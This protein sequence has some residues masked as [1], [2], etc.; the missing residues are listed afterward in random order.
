[1]VTTAP[2]GSVTAGS[3]FGLVVS[4]EDPFGNVAKSFAT[5][6]TLALATNPNGATLGG[7]STVNASSGVATFSGLTLN[8]AGAGAT[9]RASGT[10]LSSA[11]TGAIT[12]TAATA[13]QLVV[14]T[15]PPGSVTA[16][17]GF[18]FVVAA[19][20]PFGNVTPSFTS[21]LTL[22]LA[23]NPN[24][25]NLGGTLAV[26]ASAGVATF[27]GLTLNKTGTGASLLVSNPGLTG[28][29]TSVITV[30]P[31]AA[32]QLL[33][34]TSP[35]ASVTA[36]SGFGL[37]VTAEDLFGNVAT[38]FASSVTLGLAVNPNGATLGGTL[39]VNAGA[40]VATFSSLTLNKAGA[41]TTLG[42]SSAG[43]SA[44]TTGALTVTSAKA[45][46][47][48]LTTQPP[49]GVT[50]GNAFGLVA[51]AEDPFGNVDPSFVSSVN[52]ALA[53]N[54]NGAILGGTPTV[55]A[56]AGVATFSGLTLDEAGAVVTLGAS[57]SGLS[58]ATTGAITVAAETATRLVVTAQPSASVSAGTGFG[59]VVMAEDGFGNVDSTFTGGVSLTLANNP[60]G[61]TLGGASTVHA[62]AGVATFS[63][64]TLNKAGSGATLG[65]S[66]A[67]VSSTTTGAV[68]VTAAT[69]SQL[70]V[71]T[72]PPGNVTAGS[73][74][75]LVVMAE[76]PFGNVNPNFASN[77]TLALANNP[78][79]A[80]LGGI[81]AVNAAA[82][83]ATFSGLILNK[84]GTG[85]SLLVSC[86]G[87]TA[88]TTSD[89]TVTPGTA[90]QLLVTA[91]PPASV[92][93]GSGFG[94]G[95]VAE[96]PFGNTATNFAAS[97]TL[98]LAN[99]PNG[100][101]LGGTLAI[102]AAAGVATFSG[103]TLNKAGTGTT[104]LGFPV[105]A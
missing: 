97:V 92:T 96:D 63:G 30:T 81:L 13:S 17:S 27:S 49:A 32:T 89:I 5:S 98:T 7:T 37:V 75:G 57:A 48:V 25:A 100:A 14:T 70:V 72:A 80:S 24:G 36:G 46:Q 47:L 67:G 76:D 59:L 65:V 60:N 66:G 99:N 103:L 74:F 51:T 20:D 10:G 104:L 1:M 68:A 40:G 16:G 54:P 73:G 45:S 4:A 88:A 58:P 91:Q 64:L 41:G 29:T 94:I 12:V 61:A 19:E 62:I 69:A 2:P 22:A 42:A 86:T 87:L 90:T 3:G 105:Q 35:P 38:S 44:A 18:G 26:N 28:V 43:L 95:V 31:G 52:L 56:S 79:G 102:N 34:T 78:N 93:A 8:K 53:T 84:A 85:A 50:A 23:T 9:L 83:V 71:T 82:G 11:T 33:V 21:G 6:V 55:N 15:V 101:N 39:T 77:V